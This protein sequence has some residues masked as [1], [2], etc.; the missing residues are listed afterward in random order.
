MVGAAGTRYRRA[1]AFLDRLVNWEREAGLAFTSESIRLDLFRESLAG[2][3]DPQLRYPTVLVAGTKGKGSTSYLLARLLRAHGHKVGLY[4]SPH[5]SDVRERIRL[6]EVPIPRA[7]FAERIERLE[8]SLPY[9]REVGRS[10]TYFETLTAAA[11]LYFAEEKVDWAVLEVGLG[12]RLDATNTAEPEVSVL[13]PVSRDHMRAL[14]RNVLAIA[15][16]KAGIVR[17]NG[18]VVIGKQSPRVERFFLGRARE[19]GARVRLHGVDFR[20]RFLAVD[21][22]G[23]RFDYEGK[24]AVWRGIRLGLLGEHQAANAASAIQALSLLLPAI[25][26]GAA[27][28]ALRGARWAGRGELLRADPPVLLDGAHNGHSADALARLTADLYPGR[29]CLLVFGGT[30]GKEHAVIFRRLLPGAA[31]V[32]LT[33]SAHPRRRP[34]DELLS[35]LRKVD[36]RIP[37]LVVRDAGEALRTA[38]A[39]QGGRPLVITGSLYLAGEMRTLFRRLLAERRDAVLA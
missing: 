28:Q 13:T 14:G 5:L 3:G 25:D 37:C 19:I 7:A 24:G 11:F 21:E 30:K 8:A 34:A 12:G 33:E 9:F 22:G 15:A 16:E 29:R 35:I 27:R 4:T 32:V 38:L 26:E 20:S 23:T 2:L 39:R 36:A 31:E 18:A 10:R 6:N 17:A 1:L